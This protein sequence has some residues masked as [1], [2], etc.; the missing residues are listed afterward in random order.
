LMQVGEEILDK[1]G[2]KEQWIQ[3]DDECS[4]IIQQGDETPKEYVIIS[5]STPERIKNAGDGYRMSSLRW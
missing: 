2:K 3:V 1:I 5:N 4:V